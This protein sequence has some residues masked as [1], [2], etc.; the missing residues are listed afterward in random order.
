M[1]V[2]A[3]SYVLS[4]GFAHPVSSADVYNYTIKLPADYVLYA[5]TTVPAATA[6]SGKGP[7]GTWTAFTLQSKWSAT[8][9][10]T[11]T[12]TIVREANL[13]ANVAISSTNA[14]FSSANILNSTH[15]GYSVVLGVGMNATFS[16]APSTYPEGLNGTQFLWN[17]GDGTKVT[18]T[19][20][21]TNHTY[22]KIGPDGG[23]YPY[24]GTLE[25]VSSSGRNNTTNFTVW[26][27]DTVPTAG[28]AVNSTA[29]QNKTSGGVKY[30]F[31]NWSTT[32]QFNATATAKA[33]PNNISIAYYTLKAKNYTTTANYSV[34]KG[35]NAYSNWTVGFGSNTSSNVTG[36]GHGLYV[37]FSTVK[38]GGQTVDVKGNG[39]IYNLTL[40]V[41]SL[42]GTSSKATLT[43]L[44]N[45][46]EPPA[47]AFSLMNS[48]GKPIT[49]G[50][51]TENS[52]HIAVVRLNAS[53]TV[54]YGNGS[55]RLYFWSINNTN[56]TNFKNFTYS[57]TTLKPYPELRLAPKTSDYTIK[58]T[59][60][61]QNGVKANTTQKLAVAQNTT[62]RPLMYASNLTGPAT[63]NAGSSYQY[64]VNVTNKGGVKST[65]LDVTVSF[66]LQGSSGTGSK[67]Y[68]AGSPSSV[69]FYG[70]SNN[71]TNATL[72]TTSL[73][74]GSVAKIPYGVNVRAIVTWTPGTSGSFILYAYAT[75]TNQFVNNSTSSIASTPITIH[76][77]PT[78]QLLEYGG[79]AAAAII[80]LAVIILLVRRRGRKPAGSKPSS[81]SSSKSG[82]ERA[83]RDDDDEDDDA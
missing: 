5:N 17:F 73:G 71:S 49:S 14:S 36:P 11:A 22:T 83:K 18:V 9:A 79:I 72:N 20:V 33:A 66:Y 76:P 10:A 37:N 16:A 81:S 74:T 8:T 69:V 67:T 43:I 58:L 78:T 6:L 2:N 77:N 34:A 27:L 42:V 47:A 23:K 54:S 19:N 45:D 80:V 52:N 30:L 70:Y 39:W 15:K 44:V 4:F 63:V 7:S 64:W 62:I 53:A 41:W 12:F 50:S 55:I 21:T 48:A 57:N 38:I 29:A 46:T 60:T 35:A 28:I 3:T 61:S 13:T 24:N 31:V 40:T 56:T 65:A 59:V 26:V 51:I 1:P 82:L 32:L 75:A 25:I 68:I